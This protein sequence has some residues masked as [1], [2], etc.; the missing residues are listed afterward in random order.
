MSIFDTENIYPDD[1]FWD[2]LGFVNLKS[3][4]L[5]I[6]SDTKHLHWDIS[7]TCTRC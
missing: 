5:R 6:T 7:D 4:R 3:R 2:E 1:N